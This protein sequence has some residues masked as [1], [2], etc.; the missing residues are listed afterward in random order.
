M[1]RA[2]FTTVTFQI[3]PPKPVVVSL[4]TAGWLVGTTMNKPACLP[5]ILLVRWS[6]LLQ[7]FQESPT[8]GS[9]FIFHVFFCDNLSP[10]KSSRNHVP[11]N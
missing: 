7:I 3:W 6:L 1:E 9:Q 5:W 10:K 4:W 2:H 8:Y 11:I